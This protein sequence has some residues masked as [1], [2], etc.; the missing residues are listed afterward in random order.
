MDIIETRIGKILE[1]AIVV[2]VL[3]IILRTL[4]FFVFGAS[5]SQTL[6]KFHR[7]ALNILVHVPER[8]KT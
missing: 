4:Q 7:K 5:V 8:K 3:K 2:H 6:K 1:S